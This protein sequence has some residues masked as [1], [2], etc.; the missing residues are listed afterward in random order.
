MVSVSPKVLSS[1]N[2]SRPP[3]TG[4]AKTYLKDLVVPNV[5][6]SQDEKVKSASTKEKSASKEPVE[7]KKPTKST[8]APAEPS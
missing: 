6:S 7:A 4:S 5:S 2:P 3:L 1:P 8:R